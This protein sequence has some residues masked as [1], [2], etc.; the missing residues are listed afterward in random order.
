[1]RHCIQAISIIVIDV[2]VLWSVCLSLCHVR[3]LC[4]NGRRYRRQTADDS[5]ISLPDSVNTLVN[6]FLSK[7]CLK[8]TN[9]DWWFER[10]RHSTANCGPMVRASGWSQWRAYRKPPSLFSPTTSSS[11]K[12]NVQDLL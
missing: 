2:T 8:V 1:M 3:V 10:R 12:C 9:P 6:P 11:P 4:S 5:V 7:F